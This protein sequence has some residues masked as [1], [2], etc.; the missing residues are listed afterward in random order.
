MKCFVE[1][2][3]SPLGILVVLSLVV[4]V[5]MEGGTLAQL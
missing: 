3:S 4:V 1:D 2:V 5:G